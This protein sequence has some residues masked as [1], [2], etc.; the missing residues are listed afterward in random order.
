MMHLLLFEK[1]LIRQVW[2]LNGPATK[3]AQVRAKD[4]LAFAESISSPALSFDAPA[5]W[6]FFS[7]SFELPHE[8]NSAD[9]R[10]GGHIKRY[11]RV[12]SDS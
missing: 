9:A 7:T 10:I 6:L 11:R 5:I 12:S 3:V 8:S 2:A 4:R 1:L